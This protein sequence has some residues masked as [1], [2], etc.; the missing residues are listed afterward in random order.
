MFLTLI[1]WF[2]SLQ[3]YAMTHT[4]Q[5]VRVGFK[6]N[7]PPY[8]FVQYTGSVAGMH[9]DIMNWIGKN[10]GLS[11]EY[12]NYNTNEECL[13]ALK[14]NR[15][16]VVLGWPVGETITNN[17]KVVGDLSSA[18]ICVIA[19]NLTSKTL[20]NTLDYRHYIVGVGYGTVSYSYLNHMNIQG[21]AVYGN[22]EQLCDALIS[23]DVK[24]AVGIEESF[25]YILSKNNLLDNYSVINRHI[26]LIRFSTLVHKENTDLIAGITEALTELRTSGKY[27][28]I[29]N[30]W[31]IDSYVVH[32][33]KRLKL[34]IVPAAIV[35]GIGLIVII[36]N[37]RANVLLKKKVSDK[38]HELRDANF[39]LSQQMKQLQQESILRNSIIENSPLSMIAFDCNH[40]ISF[41]NHSAKKFIPSLEKGIDIR[42]VCI[43]KDIV[44]I[45]TEGE[46]IRTTPNSDVIEL[47]FFDDKK[48][49][50]YAAY[51]LSDF[52]YL[53]GTLI[54]VEDI[55]IEETKKKKLIE[56]DKNRSLSRLITG[57]AH[58]IKNPLMSIKTAVAL[59]STQGNDPEIQKAF[60]TFVPGEVDRINRLVESL[61]SYSRPVKG[62][63]ERIEV[64]EVIT[65][66]LYFV[67][68][69]ARRKNISIITDLKSELY[70]K[71]NRD[72]LKQA[73]IN[74]FIN[75]IE[76]MEHKFGSCSRSK[77]ALILSVSC[78]EEG[79]NI[80]IAIQDEGEGMT[81]DEIRICTEPFISTKATGTGLGLALVKQ[82]VQ[83]NK[84]NMTIKSEKFQYT[85]IELSFR[86]CDPK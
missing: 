83:E 34:L 22:Q 46:D 54:T 2:G 33:K 69:T 63:R 66:C 53:S 13:E 38:T 15:I 27:E 37:A 72:Q 40:K 64:S 61:I 45:V 75:S 51:H 43:F 74:L 68:V 25:S 79:D 35:A 23:G 48:S 71:M 55:T 76:S 11:I 60:T 7:M 24:V 19:D 9:I 4:E 39:A 16:D 18:S 62:A 29:N 47:G 82:F 10:K 73:L 49:Y 36:S 26:S 59:I 1:L 32:V 12:M 80:H 41:V 65:E 42:G 81:E 77:R 31:V 28:E 58:E 57:L 85:K 56:T 20:V 44:K 30:R 3:S 67:D 17:L 78:F 5:V 84:G 21:Y 14:D 50:R 70:I 86:K 52:T 6:S 8:Q